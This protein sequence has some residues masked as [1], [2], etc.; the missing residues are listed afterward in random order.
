MRIHS[1]FGGISVGNF[2]S[3]VVC[4]KKLSKSSAAWSLSKLVSHCYEV[5]DPFVPVSRAKRPANEPWTVDAN[6]R[7]TEMQ[8][9]KKTEICL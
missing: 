4:K 7:K 6:R 5:V 3:S 2:S 9:K 8:K 1:Y